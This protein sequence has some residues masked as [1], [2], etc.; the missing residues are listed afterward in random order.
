MLNSKSTVLVYNEKRKKKKI[1]GHPIIIL[2]N[3]HFTHIRLK[4][5]IKKAD[6]V[7]GL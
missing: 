1:F 6:D 4:Y 3:L 2:S 5:K 7:K